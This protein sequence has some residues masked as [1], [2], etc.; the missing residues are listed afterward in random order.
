MRCRESRTGARGPAA[1]SSMPSPPAVAFTPVERRPAPWYPMA[2]A[3]PRHGRGKR[4]ARVR[5]A[6]AASRGMRAA[7]LRQS[8]APAG[9]KKRAGAR[10]G[11]LPLGC[12]RAPCSPCR[13]EESVAASASPPWATIHVMTASKSAVCVQRGIGMPTL[14]VRQHHRFCEATRQNAAR[15]DTAQRLAS[16]VPPA[17]DEPS[18][19]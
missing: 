8:S 13:D 18:F 1:P 16:P 7:E 11:E 5:G 6:T 2:P 12:S 14:V 9:R 15:V 3:T 19:Y 10:D 4:P 17:T